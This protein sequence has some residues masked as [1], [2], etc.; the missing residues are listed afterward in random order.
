MPELPEVENARRILLR[1]RLPG[2]TITGIQIGWPNSVKYPALED[3]VLGLHSRRVQD[4]DRRGKY[5][6]LPLDSGD[7]F[8]IHLG[9]TG[10]VSVQPRSRE[11][12]S[13]VRHTF[14]LDDDG[15]CASATRADSAM[16]G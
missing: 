8:I 14:A 5:I 13:M 15:C 1:S 16:S 11:L 7:T 3:F 6:L 9:M 12:D 2:R 10:G 4:V